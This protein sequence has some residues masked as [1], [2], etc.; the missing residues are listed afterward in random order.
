[1]FS[2]NNFILKRGPIPS[3]LKKLKYKYKRINTCAYNLITT[4][5]TGFYCIF[6]PPSFKLKK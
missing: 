3:T 6:I 5:D 2:M 1:M 4:P